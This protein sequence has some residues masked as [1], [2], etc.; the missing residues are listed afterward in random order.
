MVHQPW[1]PLLLTVAAMTAYHLAQKLVPASVNPFAA[2]VLT[3]A[4]ALVVS[5]LALGFSTGPR[6]AGTELRGVTWTSAVLGLVIVALEAGAL[7][8]YR[9]GWNIGTF[10]LVFNVLTALILL[11]VG[12]V[13]FRERLSAA[14]WAG[15]AL[16][17]A[18]LGLLAR[19]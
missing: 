1:A 16:C 6:G 10:G 13:A 3:Y 8:A 7:L 19:R 18:G 9:R 11:P 12:I 15:A 4:V 5:L 17:L 14:N 2:L